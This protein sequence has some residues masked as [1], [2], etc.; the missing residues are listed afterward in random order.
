MILKLHFP[1]AELSPNERGGHWSGYAKAGKSYR[2]E[3]WAECMAQT[4]RDERDEFKPDDIIDV[5]LEFF[6]PHKWK[7]DHDGL[8]SRMKSGLDGIADAL[9]VDDFNFRITK[10]IA[11][12][13]GNYVLVTLN[14]RKVNA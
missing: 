3:C 10:D 5:H 1:V 7:Y 2:R 14:P 13:L 12:E 9:H 4:K 8:E 11:K 6:R